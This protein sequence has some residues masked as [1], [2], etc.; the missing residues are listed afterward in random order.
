MSV[1]QN[2]RVGRQERSDIQNSLSE[3]VKGEFHICLIAICTN[4]YY[5]EKTN[6]SVV[7]NCGYVCQLTVWIGGP[8]TMAKDDPYSPQSEI[9]VATHFLLDRL[10]CECF[11][12]YSSETVCYFY[13]S[14]VLCE[15]TGDPAADMEPVVA[16][17][18]EDAESGGEEEQQE[19]EQ[20]ER[21]S[22][23]P[24]DA[25]QAD[26]DGQ[27]E[28]ELELD[29]EGEEDS[30]YDDYLEAIAASFTLL[31][32]VCLSACY[33]LWFPTT[34][35]FAVAWSAPGNVQNNV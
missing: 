7:G 27:G 32:R 35:R 17:Q 26:S 33:I 14:L 20:F 16:G 13:I 6:S 9:F 10:K 4:N 11:H 28:V 21:S 25:G 8:A 1:K 31:L 5:A 34:R 24:G 3:A 30:Y 23:F 15:Q 29:S 22:Y 2:S 18:F 19:V 12:V